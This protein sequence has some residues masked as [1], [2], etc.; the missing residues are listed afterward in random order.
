MLHF[1]YLMN[2]T[3]L[4]TLCVRHKSSTLCCLPSVWFGVSIFII[5][6]FKFIC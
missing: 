5:Y 2:I 3:W 1:I 4:I 6:L